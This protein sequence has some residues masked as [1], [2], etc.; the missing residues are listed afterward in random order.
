MQHQI[1]RLPMLS[2]CV[3][4]FAIL[5]SSILSW[6]EKES[7]VTERGLGMLL[8][9]SQNEDCDI[10]RPPSRQHTVK[11]EIHN[12]K[13][14]VWSTIPFISSENATEMVFLYF[15][16]F[17]FFVWMRMQNV[18]VSMSSTYLHW[19]QWE[20]RTRSLSTLSIRRNERCE[21]SHFL[22]PDNQS[23]PIT[24]KM[25]PTTFCSLL[26]VTPSIWRKQVLKHLQ[27]HWIFMRRRDKRMGSVGESWSR[28]SCKEKC[29][30]FRSRW[31]VSPSGISHDFWVWWH[32]KFRKFYRNLKALHG[33][34]IHSTWSWAFAVAE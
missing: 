18:E 7:V 15:V 22:Q 9:M 31:S 10:W 14:L 25:P 20:K 26:L 4:S 19:I 24:F 34:C 28:L 5:L 6:N 3:C 23:N 32:Q 13:H 17:F 30:S 12:I 29:S 8:N 16:F 11:W 1:S 33:K 27:I 21:W 2:C